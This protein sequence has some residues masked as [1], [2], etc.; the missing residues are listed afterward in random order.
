MEAAVGTV[1]A[2][3]MMWQKARVV[4]ERVMV[5]GEEVGMTKESM[6]MESVGVEMEPPRGEMVEWVMVEAMTEPKMKS[7]P[8]MMAEAG[9][10]TS[11]PH[12]ARRAQ[13]ECEDRKGKDH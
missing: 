12:P 11:S 8:A 6:V 7:C 3:V 4:R 1:E 2:P 10:A 5:T 9:V 13:G